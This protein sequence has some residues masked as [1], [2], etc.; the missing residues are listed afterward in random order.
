[1][2][3]RHFEE[4]NL[5]LAW[6]DQEIPNFQTPHEVRELQ[7]WRCLIATEQEYIDG[8]IA[9]DDL[10]DYGCLSNLVNANLNPNVTWVATDF[11]SVNNGDDF[12]EEQEEEEGGM[13][14]PGD[15]E[16][17]IIEL[18]EGL[19]VYPNP[20]TS[21]FKYRNPQLRT[22]SNIKV[23]SSKGVMIQDIKNPNDEGSIDLSSHSNGLYIITFDLADKLIQTK[24]LLMK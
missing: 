5:A 14:S 21:I 6:L 3:H 19:I 10:F 18:E 24:V 4:R 20:S 7:N 22:I 15:A 8:N 2:I 1:M 17:N 13:P 11:N 23:Y 12:I 16:G 9:I